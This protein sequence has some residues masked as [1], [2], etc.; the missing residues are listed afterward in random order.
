MRVIV[1]GVEKSEQLELIK[2]F[3]GHEIQGYLLGRPSPDP[4]G[5]IARFLQNRPDETQGVAALPA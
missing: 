5:Q 1:E 3:G 2:T 4:A